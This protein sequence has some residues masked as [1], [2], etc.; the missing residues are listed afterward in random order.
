[1]C[2]K[3][4]K[5]KRKKVLTESALLE[6]DGFRVLSRKG[7]VKRTCNTA[8]GLPFQT[9]FL[10]HAGSPAARAPKGALISS[11]SRTRPYSAPPENCSYLSG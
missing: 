6:M 3:V 11:Q 4:C 10:V 5:K 1:V 2:E 9:Q 8:P 7:R